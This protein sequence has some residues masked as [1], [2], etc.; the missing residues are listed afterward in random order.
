MEEQVLKDRRCKEWTNKMFAR[1]EALPNF[2]KKIS[3]FHKKYTKRYFLSWLSL[4]VWAI[5]ITCC[6][7]VNREN[8]DIRSQSVLFKL[9]K[10]WENLENHL[11]C[12]SL[13][14]FSTLVTSVVLYSLTQATL[15]SP[16]KDKHVSVNIIY[17][18][19]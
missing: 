6:E 1:T 14:K 2:H 10:D 15:M 3:G 12:I 18:I 8:W 11:T 17:Y 9:K 4:T 19:L 5:L 7:F 13:R 16:G